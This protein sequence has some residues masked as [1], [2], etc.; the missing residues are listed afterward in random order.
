VCQFLGIGGEVDDEAI[1]EVLK[2]TVHGSW[3][4]TNPKTGVWLKAR[5]GGDDYF[6]CSECGVYIE[7]TFFAND[8]PV[9]CCPS[10]CTPMERGE[11]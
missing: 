11:K 7:A 5:I 3:K 1:L 8:Y 10:C 9:N 6:K 4:P 2:A